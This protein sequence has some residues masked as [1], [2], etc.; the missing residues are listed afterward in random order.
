MRVVSDVDVLRRYR[1][2]RHVM[3]TQQAPSPNSLQ[4]RKRRQRGNA[5]VEF[6]LVI[7]PLFALVFLMIDLAWMLF[8][9]ACL[10]EG[11][12]E[13]VRFG[14]TGNPPSYTGLDAAIVQR[15]KLCS[16]GFLSA[17]TLNA[18]SPPSVKIQYFTPTNYTDVTGQAGATVGGNVLKVTAS[19]TLKSI[20]PV[21]QKN[22]TVMGTFAPWTVTLTA[23][24]SDCM[25]G[26]PSS[27]PPSE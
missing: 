7:I 15:V 5:I 6:G 21:W 26:S 22:N 4:T 3:T 1:P 14:V 25:E 23:T 12:R 16:F 10:Q 2:L 19:M 18:G 20:I 9:L 17:A 24:S 13:G 27:G 8:G 11:V